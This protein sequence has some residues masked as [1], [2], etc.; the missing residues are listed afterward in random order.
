VAF[1][2]GRR[3]DRQKLPERPEIVDALPAYGKRQDHEVRAARA[4]GAGGRVSGGPRQPRH[5]TRSSMIHGVL[6]V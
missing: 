3:I 4:L 2:E 5:L 1:L 6:L